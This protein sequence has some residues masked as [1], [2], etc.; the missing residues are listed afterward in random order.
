MIAKERQQR[1]G[2]ANKLM[3]SSQTGD[4]HVEGNVEEGRDEDE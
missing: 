1:R 2:K 3:L 4:K